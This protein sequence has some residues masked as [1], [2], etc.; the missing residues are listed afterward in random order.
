MQ[1]DMAG[2]GRSDLYTTTHPFS[3]ILRLYIA[4]KYFLSLIYKK[5]LYIIRSMFPIALLVLKYPFLI[6]CPIHF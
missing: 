3:N 2:G 1:F 5:K 4:L 6:I